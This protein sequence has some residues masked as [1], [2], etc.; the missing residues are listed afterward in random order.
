MANRRDDFIEL[1]ARGQNQH[2]APSGSRESALR[3]GLAHLWCKPS[4]FHQNTNQY[5]GKAEPFRTSSGRAA[6]TG[7]LIAVSAGRNART[8]GRPSCM[9]SAALPRG[10]ERHFAFGLAFSYGAQLSWGVPSIASFRTIAAINARLRAI[11]NPR[12][13]ISAPKSL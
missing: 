8:S 10:A 12:R 2:S 3:P 5:R 1:Q 7:V 4:A 11:S 13:R 9:L 6:D